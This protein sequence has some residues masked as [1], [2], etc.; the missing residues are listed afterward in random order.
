[1]LEPPVDSQD[2]V[3]KVT[4]TVDSR[5]DV[6]EVTP[7]VDSRDDVKELAYPVDSRDDEKELTVDSQDDVK[8]PGK[9]SL[10]SPIDLSADSDDEK[11]NDP[12]H[13]GH[14]WMRYDSRNNEH[15]PIYIDNGDILSTATYIRYV[16]NGED[17]IL[18]GTDG[19]LYPIYRKALHSRSHPGKPNTTNDKLICDDHLFIMDPGSDLQ[20]LVDRAVHAQKDPG[21]TADVVRFRAQKNRQETLAAKLKALEEDTCLNEDALALTRRHL[22]H[23]RAATR[24][25]NAMYETPAPEAPTHRAYFIPKLRGA[26]GPADSLRRAH[27]PPDD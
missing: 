26:Q 4:P 19:K 11:E 21:L 23:A 22:I 9:G 3:K 12:D 1:M 24:I 5:D 25:F 27:T 17:T 16:F 13:P 10:G 14:G 8:E 7:T 2:D 20:E 15:Y 6:K 18:E